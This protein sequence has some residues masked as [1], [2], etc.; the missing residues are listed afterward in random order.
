MLKKILTIMFAFLFFDSYAKPP[1]KA[2]VMLFGTFHFASPGL[3]KVKTDTLDVLTAENQDYLKA[4]AN[5]ISQGFKPTQVLIECS[6]KNAD[7]IN[8]SYRQYLAGK[9]QLSVNENDQIGFR[10]AKK[11]G[12]NK[13]TCYDEREIQWN[14][15]R[16]FE[17]LP[18]SAPEIK[19]TVDE[20][21]N[22]I[23]AEINHMQ[24]TAS[25]A[26]N[27]I[28]NNS[29]A[30]DRLNKSFYL[31][32]NEVEADGHYSGADAAASWWHRNFRMYANI[33]K[34]AQPGERVI[35]IAG[36]GHTAILKDLLDLDSRRIAV[37][38]N[39]FL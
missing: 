11:A 37:K 13:V 39:Q 10:V 21:I 26:E 38:V 4:L 1:E 27:L 17:V 19:K 29:E 32:T 22:K 9:Y 14:S 15:K 31:L 6:K 2:Q 28:H 8:L 18:E 34:A 33:Q 20:F 30:F 23:T 12:L 25:L 5:R 24:Q 16:L 35:A 7:K 36:Q 3:D